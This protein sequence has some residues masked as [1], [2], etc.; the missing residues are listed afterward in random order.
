MSV[1]QGQA[2]VHG[3]LGQQPADWHVAPPWLQ[4]HGPGLLL[5]LLWH[6]AS[7]S[8]RPGV[9]TSVWPKSTRQSDLWVSGVPVLWALPSGFLVPCAWGLAAGWPQQPLWAPPELCSQSATM[10]RLSQPLSVNPP[11]ARVLSGPGRFLGVGWGMGACE[12]GRAVW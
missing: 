11:G 6:G 7:S 8:S 10:I 12:S 4:G 9:V 1:G 5:G 2:G 3:E